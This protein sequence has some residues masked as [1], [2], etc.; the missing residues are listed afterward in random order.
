M[1]WSERDQKRISHSVVLEKRG[2]NQEKKKEFIRKSIRSK[3]KKSK[4]VWK[5][6]NQTLVSA[7]LN[8]MYLC[9]GWPTRK[10]SHFKS[11]V[12]DRW[13]RNPKDADQR[14]FYFYQGITKFIFK[15]LV[16]SPPSESTTQTR[17]T[18]LQG[19]IIDGCEVYLDDGLK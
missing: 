13:I 7:K 18:E 2:G 11:T 15:F 3:K 8:K 19:L 14:I 1:C 5:K 17:I 6:S 9:C 10:G 16:H 4:A 12:K